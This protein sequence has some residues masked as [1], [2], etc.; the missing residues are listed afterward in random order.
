MLKCKILPAINEYFI[1]E[2]AARP[3]RVH[4]NGLMTLINHILHSITSNLINVTFIL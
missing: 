3:R 2:N 4:L 1:K